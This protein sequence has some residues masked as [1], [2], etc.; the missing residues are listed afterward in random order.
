M[1]RERILRIIAHA[2]RFKVTYPGWRWPRDTEAETKRAAEAVL[3]HIELSNCTVEAG[4]AAKPHST[5]GGE[6]PR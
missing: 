5:H 1:S 2:L 6:P 4:E 3:A